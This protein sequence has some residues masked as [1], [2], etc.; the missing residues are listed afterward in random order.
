[1]P[2]A[3]LRL[4]NALAGAAATVVL[5]LLARS[6]FGTATALW[7]SVFLALDVNATGINRI[8]KE[9]TFLVLFLL[10]GIWFYE[11]A[12]FRHLRDGDS[13]HRWYGASG[14]AFGLM[15][16]SKYMPYY[17]GLWALFG[18]AASK[19]ARRAAAGD[20]QAVMS[21]RQRASKWFHLAMLGGFVIA[22][23]A[24]LHPATWRYLL[25]Y[26]N[27]ATITHHGAFFAG[28]VYINIMGATPWGLPWHFYLVYLFTKT[29]LPV[30]GLVALGIVELARRRRERGAVFARVFLLL[31][32][33]PASLMASKFGRYLLPTV[34]VLDIVA[35]LGAV[36]AFEWLGRVSRPTVRAVAAATLAVSIVGAPLTAQIH[37]SPYPSLFQN[38][39]GHHLSAPG[40]TF[41]NDELYDAGVR[42]AVEW[43]S[44]RASG[45]AS[46]AS[47]APDVVAEY[48]RRYGRP[49]IEARS[50]SMAGL[51]MPP[52]ETWLLAEDSHACFESLQ[53]VEQ[54]RRRQKPD[55]V[56]QVH[57]T[58]AVEAFRLPW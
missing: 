53:V 52:T 30:L 55:F 17:L 7:A 39:I 33:L 50:L 31:F 36:R 12:R 38:T 2:E 46:I 11:E 49:D 21:T 40:T 19:E 35:A 43:I 28:Q 4:P 14:A 45:G 22:N 9:D 23:P 34:V 8:G 27:G 51:A 24:I 48:L 25:G 26:M 20:D 3:S 44:R 54:V 32:L 18:I 47:D 41:P 10:L 37:W 58:P 5:F 15:I 16:A 29:P 1:S 57:G 6:F 56:Y 13:P 42:E